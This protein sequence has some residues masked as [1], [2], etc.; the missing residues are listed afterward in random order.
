MKIPNTKDRYRLTSPTDLGDQFCKKI[1]GGCCYYLAGEKEKG[2]RRKRI[3]E[4]IV[5]NNL[6]FADK[7]IMSEIL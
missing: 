6:H 4:G 5:G 3:G 1:K 2:E 7:I